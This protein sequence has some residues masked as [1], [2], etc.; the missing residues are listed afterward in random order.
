MLSLFLG[1]TK[2]LLLFPSL[3]LHP[4]TCIHS[5]V[6]VIKNIYYMERKKIL[7]KFIQKK[8][9]YKYKLNTLHLD[10]LIIIEIYK[11]VD[12]S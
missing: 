4:R 12:I 11:E 2:A 3:S 5:M 10:T 8:N 6:Y 7:Y 9:L 1:I